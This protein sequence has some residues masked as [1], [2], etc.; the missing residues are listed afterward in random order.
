MPRW[1]FHISADE[2]LIRDQEGEEIG[3][4]EEAEGEARQI[5]RDAMSEQLRRGERL[6]LDWWVEV[7]KCG[8]PVL[9]VSFRSIAL[10]DAD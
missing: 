2:E 10:G 9:R 6:S 4:A 5:A 8:Q 7:E 3:S 1:F